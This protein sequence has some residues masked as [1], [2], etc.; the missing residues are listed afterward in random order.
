MIVRRYRE[1]D[2]M[3]P[4]N[5]RQ[6]LSRCTK[7]AVAGAG[8]AI[9]PAL[10][11]PSPAYAISLK[12]G[13]IGRKLSPY[14]TPLDDKAIQCDLCPH[15]CEVDEGE[16]GICE[17]R[18]NIKGKYYSLVYGNPCSLN[19][20]PTEKKPFYHVL[21]T[22]K[23]FSIATAGCNFDCKFC[24]NWQISQARPEETINYLATPGE[25]VKL[26]IKYNCTSIASTYVEPTVFMEYMLEI[27]RLT[28]PYPL[29]KVMHSNG[30]IN[31]KPLDDLCKYLDAACID[32]KAITESFYRDVSEG[33][34]QPVLDTLKQLKANGVHT[35][36]VNLV[37]PGKNDDPDQVRKMVRW[38]A[39]ELGPDV[40]LHFSRFYPLYKLKS[41]PPTSIQ[42]LEQIRKIALAEGLNYVYLG[43]VP[44]HP[45]G[46]TY[47]PKCKKMLIKRIGYNVKVLSMDSGSCRFCGHP[48]AG[49]W[50]QRQ[51][52]QG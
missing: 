2:K 52:T 10:L 31:P 29:L 36:L 44:E 21:P 22:T 1:V 50:E 48:I 47:C 18:E 37:I 51:P 23:S 3:E 46:H 33:R 24:Q 17:A 28:R 42:S 9:L 4:M 32:L 7:C 12:K 8:T 40:P 14:Y 49:I 39:S 35:E 43:N 34:L 38:I 5:R 6:F 30:F 20:D 19:V 26:A 13:A 25:I 41:I 45:G 11:R 27:G 15:E 16:R